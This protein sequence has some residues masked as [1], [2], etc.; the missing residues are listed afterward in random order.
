[1]N[2]NRTRPVQINPKSANADISLKAKQVSYTSHFLV[3]HND[4]VSSI[5]TRSL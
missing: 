1:M 4:A 5:V 3:N 2:H